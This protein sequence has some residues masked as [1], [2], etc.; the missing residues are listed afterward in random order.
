MNGSPTATQSEK[1]MIKIMIPDP[2]KNAVEDSAAS[3]YRTFTTTASTVIRALLL[4]AVGLT[5]WLAGGAD[6]Q[7]ILHGIQNSTWLRFSLIFAIFGLVADGGQYIYASFAYDKWLKWTTKL[8][9]YRNEPGSPEFEDAVEKLT[10]KY[11]LTLEKIKKYADSRGLDA[12][13]I[14]ETIEIYYA[15][16][17]DLGPLRLEFRIKIIFWTKIIFAGLAYLC[18]L[19]G[20]FF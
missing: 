20:I 14:A 1:G 6:A 10:K 9:K 8:W 19:I 13:S 12:S 7:T 17:N 3:E 18:V 11:G 4:A 15:E 2:P 5:C 16:H